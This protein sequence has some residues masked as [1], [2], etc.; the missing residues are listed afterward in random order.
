MVEATAPP[1][2]APVRLK[3]AAIAIACR[4]VSTS[5]RDDRGDGIGGVVKAIAVLEN[6][7]GE[8]DQNERD[9]AVDSLRVFEHDLQDDV[10][11]VAA[12]IDHFL[13]ANRKDRAEK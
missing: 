11:R 1:K 2:N 13:R 5:R 12:A 4:G 3:N 10:P 6:D 8:N 9:H 7:G